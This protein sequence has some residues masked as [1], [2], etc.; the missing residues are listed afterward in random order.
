MYLLIGSIEKIVF[1]LFI[2]F[3]CTC[4]VL[5]E[6]CRALVFKRKT[7]ICSSQVFS[8]L[9]HCE[10]EFSCSNTPTILSHFF[11]SRQ[12]HNDVSI[13]KNNNIVVHYVLIEM[14]LN[15]EKVEVVVNS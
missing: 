8:H 5:Q 7:E 10:Y 4:F 9:T 11:K 12:R 2:L 3:H 6:F 15:N 13:M 1:F 14:M